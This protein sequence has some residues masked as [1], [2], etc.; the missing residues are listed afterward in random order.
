MK[1]FRP[2]TEH[3]RIEILRSC[4]KLMASGTWNAI[5]VSELEKHIRQTRGA[6]FYFYKNKEDLFINMIDELFLPVFR[7]SDSDK[8]RFQ[9]CGTDIFFSSYRFPFERVSDDLRI[10]YNVDHPSRTM[11]NIIAQAQK[12]YPKFG[13]IIK[14]AIKSELDF[15]NRLL[16]PSKIKMI[17]VDQ[18]YKN[19]VGRLY[20]DSL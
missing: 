5:S 3:N 20:L 9:D 11:F 4:Y 8:K 16:N 15:L 18:F 6:I 2:Q 17:D 10:N 14:D 12:L 1:K 19:S 7:L 13:E